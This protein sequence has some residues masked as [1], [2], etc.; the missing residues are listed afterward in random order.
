LVILTLLLVFLCLG[1]ACVL[2]HIRHYLTVS[3]AETSVRR[4]DE[5]GADDDDHTRG[6]AGNA[7]T[8]RRE[9][10]QRR[11]GK[12]SRLAALRA[13][14]TALVAS[15]Y[16]QVCHAHVPRPIGVCG[17]APSEFTLTRTLTLIPT[18]P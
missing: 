15:G 8:Y 4:N 5:D 10:Q 12:S 7:P 11:R 9:R 18:L 2:S 17:M 16:E 14:C 3:A 1:G 6:N 13:S